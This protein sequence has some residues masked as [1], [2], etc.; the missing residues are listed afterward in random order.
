M[1]AQRFPADY[2]GIVAGAPANDWINLQT[3]SLW[4]YTATHQDEASYIPPADYALLH[5]AAV[6]ACDANDGVK[7]GVIEDPT[8]CRFDPQVLACK[9]SQSTGCLT[10]PQIEAARK[11]YSPAIN[12]RTKAQIFPGLEPGSELGWGGLASGDQAPLYV[13]ETFKYVVFADPGWDYKKRPIDYDQ[14]LAHATA[15]DHGTITASNPNLKDFFARGGKLI[16]YHGWSDPLIA[17]GH[18]VDYFNQVAAALGGASKVQ[19]SLRLYMVPGMNHCRGGE[20]TDT[21]NMQGA[22]ERWVEKGQAPG[23]IAASRVV[24]GRVQRTRPLC[25]YP[26]VAKYNGS[27]STDDAASFSCRLP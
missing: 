27:G 25:P 14:D 7:D 4:V 20:G 21:F 3:W 10:G 24:D 22:I 19:D 1:E 6:E 5:K 11:I 18:S 12:P 2:D 26:Q 15:M 17:P 23:A 8:R 16:Q 9:G 13:R